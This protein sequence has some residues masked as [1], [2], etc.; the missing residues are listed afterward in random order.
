MK[1]NEPGSFALLK[2]I[3]N[4]KFY[5]VLVLNIIDVIKYQK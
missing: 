5:V 3:F 2:E 1:N 4:E